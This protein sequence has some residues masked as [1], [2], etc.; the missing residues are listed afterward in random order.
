MV[1]GILL[2]IGLVHYFHGMDLVINKR[3]VFQHDVKG[4]FLFLSLIIILCT[5]GFP[6][7]V[8]CFTSGVLYGFEMGI[9]Y[10]VVATVLGAIFAY[11]WALWLGGEWAKKYLAH[12]KIKKLDKFIR[13]NPFSSVLM[14]RLMPVGSSLLLNVTCGIIGIRFTSFVAAA[15][16]GSTPQTIVFVLLGSGVRIGHMGQISLSLILFLASA[17][18]GLWLMKSS[19]ARKSDLS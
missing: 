15:F 1:L 10:A 2:V 16:L 4:Q 7:Q 3:N 12:K 19:F 11:L 6:R 14:F 9:L 17:F 18:L 13:E 8:V 5:V